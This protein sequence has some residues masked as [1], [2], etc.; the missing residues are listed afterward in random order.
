MPIHSQATRTTQSSSTS[1]TASTTSEALSESN[2]EAIATMEAEVSGSLGRLFNRILGVDESSTDTGAMAFSL[3]QLKDYIKNQ[4]D[5]AEGEFFRTAKI[6]GVAQRMLLELDSN[7]DGLVDWPEFQGSV[8]RLCSMLGIEQE[9]ATPE[10]VVEASD[11]SFQTIAGESQEIGLT[12]LQSHVEESMP[13]ETE[14]LD[15]VAQFAARMAIDL[16]DTDQRDLPVAERSVSQ[17]EWVNAAKDL[18]DSAS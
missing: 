8:D 18:A 14:H 10:E 3:D 6:S 4:I 2:E 13:A 15:L 5:F 11:S 12:T 1:E 9:E 16:A 7:Q 17:D